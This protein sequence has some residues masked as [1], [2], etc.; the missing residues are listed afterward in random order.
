LQSVKKKNRKTRVLLSKIGLD[1]HDRGVKVLAQLLREA[2]MEVVY[3]G[4]YQTAENIVRA[5]IQEDVEVIG[6]SILSGE[7]LTLVPKMINL[8]KK[9]NL[10][11][12]YLLLVGGV[13]PREDIPILKSSGVHEVFTAGSLVEEIA[14]Y[15]ENWLAA[16]KRRDIN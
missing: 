5:A 8:L 6:L 7:H 12:E 9:E 10:Y 14:P 11:G 1:G 15:I 4:M 2:G 13:I 3:L 16:N